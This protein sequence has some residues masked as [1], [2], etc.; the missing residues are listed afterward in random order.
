MLIARWISLLLCLLL[1]A[2]SSQNGRG[3]LPTGGPTMAE[4][5]SQKMQA[6]DSSLN[7]L[8]NQANAGWLGAAD[9][10]QYGYTRT[11][12]NELSNLFPK[13]PNPMIVMYVY[14]H[15]AGQDQAPIP[16]YSTAFTLYEKD[17][18]A[19]PGELVKG[20]YR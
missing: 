5:Y 7:A 17:H 6:D 2:C 3:V 11:A 14:P 8:R 12:N 19:L 1:A 15:L 16:G 4:I 10:S 18:Y 20:R 13:L 9:S